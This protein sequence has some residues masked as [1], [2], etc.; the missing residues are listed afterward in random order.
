MTSRALLNGS[1]SSKEVAMFEQAD[2]KFAEAMVDVEAGRTMLRT[3][4][5]AR[6]LLLW[7]GVTL[8]VVEMV[9]RFFTHT[10]QHTESWLFLLFISLSLHYDVQVKVL[11]AAAQ[12]ATS[13]VHEPQT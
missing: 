6:T 4:R 13:S 7:L 2:R 9:A 10:I 8:L 3:L 12:R 11:T 5:R 1:P